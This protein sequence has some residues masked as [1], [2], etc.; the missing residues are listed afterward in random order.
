MKNYHV[1]SIM[2]LILLQ[3]QLFPQDSTLVMEPIWTRVGDSF[4]AIDQ[5][6]GIASIESAEFSPDE[7]L[8]AAEPS[9]VG[10]SAAGTWLAKNSGIGGT[11]PT[12]NLKWK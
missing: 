6:N 8:I 11:R 7:K 1:I 9:V 12:L 4:G 3:T 10:M 5:E 2:C